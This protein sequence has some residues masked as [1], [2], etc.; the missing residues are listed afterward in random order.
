MTSDTMMRDLAP[1]PVLHYPDN[2]QRCVAMG[3]VVIACAPDEFRNDIASE[4]KRWAK[5]V[6][7]AG[8]RVE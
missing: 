4:I 6:K 8:I 7:A 5:V 2:Q 3:L 1:L